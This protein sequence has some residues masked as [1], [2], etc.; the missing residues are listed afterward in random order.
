MHQ[1]ISH[2]I[3]PINSSWSAPCVLEVSVTRN[4]LHNK[5][6]FHVHLFYMTKVR[7]EQ[8]SMAM[9]YFLCTWTVPKWADSGKTFSETITDLPRWFWHACCPLYSSRHCT[10]HIY[11]AVIQVWCL[12]TIYLLSKI[13]MMQSLLYLFHL[14]PFTNHW[15]I[16]E[17]RKLKSLQIS[18]FLFSLKKKKKV[19]FVSMP[20]FHLLNNWH[21]LN[22]K[23]TFHHLKSLQVSLYSLTTA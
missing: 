4:Y 21:W 5:S 11:K 15:Y 6:Y 1:I 16:V 20:S 22:H 7:H 9:Y 23:H 17:L 8:I 19:S 18:I 3:L 14:E 13:I 12:P 10:V 2:T